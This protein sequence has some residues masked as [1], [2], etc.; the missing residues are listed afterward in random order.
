MGGFDEI[1]RNSHVRKYKEWYLFHVVISFN[2]FY[3]ILWQTT[4]YNKI[5]TEILVYGIEPDAV[6]GKPLL[7][8]DSVPRSPYK[9]IFV[10]Y[11]VQFFGFC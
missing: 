8:S 7:D 1:Y 5:D 6:W 3:I 2:N 10:K 9:D 4:E 11:N